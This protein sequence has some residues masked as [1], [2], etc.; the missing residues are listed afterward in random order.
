MPN[1]LQYQRIAN[2]VFS[3]PWAITPAKY[4]AICAFIQ[5][6]SVGA[7]IEGFDF[8]ALDNSPS[9][10][11]AKVRV[12]PIRGTIVKRAGLMTKFSG[13][14]SAV[15]V[16]KS[17]SEAIESEDVDAIV[18]HI[19]SPG[20]TVDG[21]FALADAIR[22]ARGSK[23]IIAMGDGRCCSA[24]YLIAS[25]ADKVVLNSTGVAGSIG[26]LT[27]HTNTSKRDAKCG[28]STT[29]ISAGKYKVL[30]ASG[31]PLSQAGLEYI[32]AEV[33]YLYGMFVESVAG[34]RGA[35]VK[36][37]LKM[38]DGKVFTGQQALNIGLVDQIG[39]IG[40]AVSLATSMVDKEE[41]DFKFDPMT[42]FR[43]ENKKARADKVLLG[44]N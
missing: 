39:E 2:A 33:D 24:A 44:K 22:A 25:A 18:L 42:S 30:G 29:I 28:I 1:N 32:Q 17:F 43:A 16:G 11:D 6:K 3:E 31:P 12:I 14:V 23:P 8:D 27:S 21:S 13:G 15:E 20:G 35:T 5:A 34:N 10:T 40:D 9:S 7:G 26:V 36:D 38:A 41:K 37:T 4:E 19:D